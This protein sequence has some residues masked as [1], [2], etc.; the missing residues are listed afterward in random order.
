[1]TSFEGSREVIIALPGGYKNVYLGLTGENCKLDNI[2][3]TNT[4]NVIKEGDIDIVAAVMSFT[5]RLESDVPNVQIERKRSAYSEGISVGRRRVIKFHTQTLPDASLVWNCPYIILYSSDDG[6]V[7]GE[8]YTEYAAIKLNGEIEENNKDITNKFSV[9]KKETFVNWDSWKSVN[10]EGLEC[11]ITLE[12]KG[13]R[14]ILFTE[15]LGIAISN[16]TETG[17]DKKDVYVA[18]SGDMCALTDIRL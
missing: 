3:V 10:K 14:I 2:T 16:T 15:N 6:K 8:N 17:N 5:D 11:E 1:M 18:L 13:G 4:D 9:K 7:N 12:R